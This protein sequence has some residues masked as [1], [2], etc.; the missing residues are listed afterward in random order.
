[1]HSVITSM[2]VNYTLVK[3]RCTDLL[4]S[5][6]P[7]ETTRRSN[8]FHAAHL[9][10][11]TKSVCFACFSTSLPFP[12]QAALPINTRLETLQDADWF[13]FP[14]IGIRYE[15][16]LLMFQCTESHFW[17]GGCKKKK[18]KSCATAA[19]S[20]LTLNLIQQITQNA[21]LPWKRGCGEAAAARCAQMCHPAA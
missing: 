9:Q 14:Q 16:P 19:S 10:N 5:G 7:M 21:N 18:K 2:H 11:M 15:G 3:Q 20:E 4:R 17:R 13:I 8:R 6:R 12:L 1:M